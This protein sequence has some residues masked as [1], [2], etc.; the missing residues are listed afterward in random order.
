MGRVPNVSRSERNPGMHTRLSSTSMLLSAS[1]G[2]ADMPMSVEPT[3]QSRPRTCSAPAVTPS[4]LL[5]A[6][7]PRNLSPWKSQL[8]YKEAPEKHTARDAKEMTLFIDTCSSGGASG[9]G[10]A[11]PQ[12]PS[13]T[14][15][16]HVL[17]ELDF[18]VGSSDRFDAGE[19]FRFPD[20]HALVTVASDIGELSQNTNE[21][22]IQEAQSRPS[23]DHRSGI[24]D[25]NAY[26]RD[27]DV[28]IDVVYHEVVR[29][30]ESD[31]LRQKPDQQSRGTKPSS[32][33]N[34]VVLPLRV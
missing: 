14:A 10:V 9:E 30:L 34:P 4:P 25:A 12:N 19:E 5:D 8:S 18:E 29:R 28:L 20:S 21:R 2:A 26:Q 32:D 22:S 17:E 33:T 13:N 23:S 31:N 6:D 1:G 16:A 3:S 11:R 24:L 7:V 15:T 27:M